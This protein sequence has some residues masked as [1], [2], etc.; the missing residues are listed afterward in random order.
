MNPTVST[1]EIDLLPV[2]M[3]NEFVYCPR[4]AYLEWTDQEF[5]ASADTVDGSIRH[6]RVDK[7]SGSLP[8]EP[9]EHQPIHACSAALGSPALGLT[10]KSSI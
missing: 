3:L 5:A 4:L 6:R 1:R 9:N 7:P 10:A 2:R 8:E